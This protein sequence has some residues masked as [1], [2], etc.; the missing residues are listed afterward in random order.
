MKYNVKVRNGKL[1]IEKGREHGT[2]YD[3]RL[4]GMAALEDMLEG[5]EGDDK[6][7]LQEQLDLL[8]RCQNF[9]DWISG[10]PSGWGFG[11]F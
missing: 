1:V 11:G 9:D 3:A 5:L 7:E 8:E 2:W 6:E 10:E 4:A